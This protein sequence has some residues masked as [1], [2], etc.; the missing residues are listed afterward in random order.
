MK[1]NSYRLLVV[2]HPDDETIF[3]GGI[4]Q[5][6]KS[7]PWQVI[8]VTDGNFENRGEDRK[9]EFLAATKLLGVKATEHW[10][11]PDRFPDRLPIE[12]ITARLRDLPK[13]KEIYTHGPFGEYGHPHHQD[14]CLATHLAF[15]KCKIF[16]PAW[17]C[18]ADKVVQLTASEYKKKT[19]AYE[20]IY[21]KETSRF[22]NMVP[23]SAVEAFAQFSLPEVKTI[24]R[25]LRREEDLKTSSMKKFSWLGDQLPNL[26]DRW[27]VKLF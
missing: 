24:V 13:P 9:K 20:E 11:Y 26:R 3:F 23:N 2:A 19:K 10:R 5:R 25:F 18:Q 14:V 8:C 27:A 6:E 21:F 16:S 7:L 1:A 22:L 12:E 17:N 4:L 15:P